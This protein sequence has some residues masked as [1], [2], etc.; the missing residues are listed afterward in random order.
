V[1]SR[2]IELFRGICDV[3]S[4]RVLSADDCCK[5][6]TL[7]KQCTSFSFSLGTCFFKSCDKQHISAILKSHAPTNMDVVSEMIAFL[8]NWLT[9]REQAPP[10]EAFVDIYTPDEF[11]TP[12]GSVKDGDFSAFS[13]ALML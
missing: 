12:V 10:P 13:R 4:Q 6:C 11:G 7:K 2:N 8:D 1:P 9:R 5:L 3:N